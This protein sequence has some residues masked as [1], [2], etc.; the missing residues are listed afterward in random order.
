MM[1]WPLASWPRPTFSQGALLL[2]VAVGD[3]F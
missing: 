3:Q 2:A 1:G